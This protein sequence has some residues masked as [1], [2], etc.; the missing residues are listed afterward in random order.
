MTNKICPQ[1]GE[2]LEPGASFCSVCGADISNRT[3]GDS[4]RRPAKARRSPAWLPIIVIVGGALILVGLLLNQ[5]G[6]PTVADVP[7]EHDTAGLP[8][9]DVPRIPVAEARERFDNGTAVIVDV[10]SAQQYAE[11]HVPD[12]LSIP[13]DEIQSRYQEM[14]ADAE[15]ITYCT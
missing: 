7:D 1:C 9:P 12:A 15:I 11:A 13:L 10:R 6:P 8:Y 3:V 4:P 14:P 5:A 2:R